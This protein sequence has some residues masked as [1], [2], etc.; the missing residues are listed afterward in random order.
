MTHTTTLRSWARMATAL[1]AALCIFQL[2]GVAIAGNF[3]STDRLRNSEGVL[4]QVVLGN[5]NVQDVA[6]STTPGDPGALD[7]RRE[8]AVR[9]AISNVYNPV[10][11][12]TMRTTGGASDVVACQDFYGANAFAGWTD[13]PLTSQTGGPTGRVWCRF[14]QVRFN[15]YYVRNDG[16]ALARS[17]ACHELGH[18][19]GLRHADQQDP[20][21]AA[22]CMSPARSSSKIGITTHDTS[23]L[24][25]HY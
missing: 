2:S 9:F 3:G 19:I 13:C 11:D 18:T 23:H 21:T 8:E 17:L 15:N 25:N 16:E 5:N 7:A 12:L 1:V 14:S 24:N 22:S 6:F 20:D 10:R 4:N